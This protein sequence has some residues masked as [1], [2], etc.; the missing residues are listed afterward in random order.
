[1][2]K[3]EQLRI[4][5]RTLP[6]CRLLLQE[7]SEREV[8]PT[9]LAKPMQNLGSYRLAYQSNALRHLLRGGVMEEG[10]Y[11]TFPSFC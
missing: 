7:A 2:S 10:K 5:A 4:P 1:M 8:S 11:K 3:G 6:V 9:T